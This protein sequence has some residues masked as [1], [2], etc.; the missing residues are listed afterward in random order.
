MSANY[1]ART[2]TRLRGIPA[3]IRY[4]VCRPMGS[5]TFGIVSQHRTESGAQRSLARQRA[6]AAKQGG[7]SQDYLCE[8]GD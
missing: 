2:S 6:G 1:I 4:L 8:I 5:G 7:Y 3:S